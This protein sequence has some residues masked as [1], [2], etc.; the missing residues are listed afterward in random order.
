MPASATTGFDGAALKARGAGASDACRQ[1]A[2]WLINS[3]RAWGRAGGRSKGERLFKRRAPVQKESASPAS[4]RDA[5]RSVADWES[6]FTSVTSGRRE[7]LGLSFH[8]RS[9]IKLSFAVPIHTRHL[10][11]LF[12]P[13]HK[14]LFFL[15]FSFVPHA[16][17]CFGSTNCRRCA[18]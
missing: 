16:N 18:P 10:T 3:G 4:S 6:H 7:R 2:A 14:R 11:A 13:A 17:A 9:R 5:Y 15:G 12:N 1:A 8:T